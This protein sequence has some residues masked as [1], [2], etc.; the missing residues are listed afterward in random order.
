M[1]DLLQT[2]LDA[3]V[4]LLIVVIPVLFAILTRAAVSYLRSQQ[5]KLE[6]EN[7][8]TEAFLLERMV[9]LA[10]N[11]AEEIFDE[12][13][14]A[15][16]RDYVSIQLERIAAESGLNLNDED[17]QLLIEGSLKRV[18]NELRTWNYGPA[19]IE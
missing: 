5:V 7:R 17:V 8:E 9:G 19:R 12:E 11:T 13:Q 3:F 16:K 1:D 4:K 18:K 14:F 10:I 6:S 2:A 15:E